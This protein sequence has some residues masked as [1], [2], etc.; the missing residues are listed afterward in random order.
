M[1]KKKKVCLPTQ[2]PTYIMGCVI[3]A[4]FVLGLLSLEF[5]DV[6][7][8]YHAPGTEQEESQNQPVTSMQFI[9]NVEGRA[10]M[11]GQVVSFKG[12]DDSGDVINAMYANNNETG[13]HADCMVVNEIRDDETGWCV[14]YGKVTGLNTADLYTGN[15]FYLSNESGRITALR[16]L[17]GGQY[18][19]TVFRSH[20]SKGV[21]WVEM[22][23]E[24]Q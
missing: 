13:N 22:K 10:F 20:D 19:G 14:T 15:D 11:P 9:K 17:D 24:K 4:W 2:V 8:D 3:L 7:N 23:E 12:Y 16:P 5:N 6:Q 21:L 1:M 18:V